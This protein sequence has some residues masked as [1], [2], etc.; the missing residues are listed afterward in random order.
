M[1]VVAQKVSKDAASVDWLVVG[2]GFTGA[3]TARILAEEHGQRVL[4][5]DRRAHVAGNAFDQQEENGIL[6]HRF[7][8]HIFHTNSQR[9]WD[10][11]SRFTK[12]RSYEHHVRALINGE[13]IPIPFGFAAIDMLFGKRAFA[14]KAKLI[15][16]YGSDARVPILK[17]RKA[18]DPVIRD[19][20]EFVYE[21][22]F[23]GYTFK[24]WGCEPE[25]LDPSVTARVPVHVGDDQRYFRDRFQAMPV[26]GYSALF[27]RLL[28]HPRISTALSVS[29][30][31]LASTERLLPT[32]FTGAL[33][34]YFEYIHGELPYRSIRFRFEK[35]PGNMLRQPCGTI[36]YPNDH[37]FTRTTE[38]RWLTGQSSESSVIVKE[39][40]MPY[41]PGENEPLYPVPSPDSARLTKMYERETLQKDQRVWF[42]GRL[43]DYRYYNMDQACARAMTLVQKEIA[44]IFTGA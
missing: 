16:N 32:V 15:E 12:W 42:A 4:V 26:D 1:S 3:S 28:D 35:K 14:L 2:A 38:Q 36:N 9:V 19:L 34:E 6:V 18:R 10:F 11:L 43:G 31:D 41:R 25:A 33:D 20:A 21:K 29:Y 39:W 30:R 22:V 13:F 37:D 23:R 7:G 27:A 5:I 40:P 24:Q 8:P 44:P 17:L